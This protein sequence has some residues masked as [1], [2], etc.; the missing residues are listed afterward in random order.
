MLQ[1]KDLKKSVLKNHAKL[2]L[3][4]YTPSPRDTGVETNVHSYICKGM[5]VGYQLAVLYPIS[6]FMGVE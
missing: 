2:P 5:L 1:E 3:A 6:L 4:H